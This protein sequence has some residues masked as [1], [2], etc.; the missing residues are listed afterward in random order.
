MFER[1]FF[2]FLSKLKAVF[3]SISVCEY[4]TIET[5]PM[6]IEKVDSDGLVDVPIPS[7]HDGPADIL[8]FLMSKRVRKGMVSYCDKYTSESINK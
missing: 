8:C 3:H 6:Q 1:K 2:Y 7:A 4:F 5:Q